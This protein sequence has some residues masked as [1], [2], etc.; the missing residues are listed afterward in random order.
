MRK[1]YELYIK[2]LITLGLDLEGINRSLLAF[3]FAQLTIEE[4]ERIET[5]L[6]PIPEPFQPM[7]KSHKPTQAW[8]RKQ[9]LYSIW[10]RKDFPH[11]EQMF[12]ILSKPR[13]RFI[14][15]L[16]T[17][18][19]TPFANIAALVSDK[20]D[21][22]VSS[23]TIESYAVYF[24]N[25][26]GLSVTEF[27]QD[28]AERHEYWRIAAISG[29][30]DLLM[31]YMGIDVPMKVEKIIKDTASLSFYRMKETRY[32][33]SSLFT[34]KS[35]GEYLKGV[36][37]SVEQLKE[38]QEEIERSAIGPAMKNEKFSDPIFNGEITALEEVGVRALPEPINVDEEIIHEHQ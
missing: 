5:E 3:S 8:L 1:P 25:Y 32:L 37:W 27:R 30:K 22:K 21:Y 26:V 12:H 38:F 13:L 29:D 9:V 2:Y 11:I 15:E 31:W 7:A 20:Y 23:A 36:T 18:S 14:V 34:A 35:F 16:G 28:A 4:L 33:P 24:N 19:A 6:G 17:M 10:H